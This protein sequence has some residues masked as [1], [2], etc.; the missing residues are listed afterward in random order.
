MRLFL[1]YLLFFGIP[2][3]VYFVSFEY[4]CRNQT[5]FAIKRNFAIDNFSRFENVFTGTSHVEKGV[6]VPAGDLRY[7]NWAAPGQTFPLEYQLFKRYLGEMSSL[8]TAFI[9]ISP[10]RL[11]M[12]LNKDNWASNLYWIHYQIP[13]EVDI[14]NP[15][16]N[17]HFFQDY[18]FF[19]N[20]VHD[21]WNPYKHHLEINPNGF[22]PF[23]TTGRFYDLKF[24]TIEI[25]QTFVMKYDFVCDKSDLERNKIYLDS[26]I[27]ILNDHNVEVVLVVPPFFNTFNQSIPPHVKKVWSEWVVQ[28]QRN[29]DVKIWDFNQT[30]YWNVTDFSNDNHLNPKG[31]SKWFQMFGDSLSQ[32]KR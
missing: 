17:F 7:L 16:R 32:T 9:E 28:L 8:K 26:T 13:F 11:F 19:K 27:Q 14:Y 23:D 18:A 22:A 30:K 24:D 29:D 15:R 21:A 4:Y 25:K 2:L 6:M 5:L 10:V 12:K 31:A 20:V 3:I 1:K